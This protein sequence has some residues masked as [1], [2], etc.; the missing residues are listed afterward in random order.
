MKKLLLVCLL[1]AWGGTALAQS[2]VR[3]YGFLGPSSPLAPNAFSDFWNVGYTAGAAVGVRLIGA[4]EVVGGV[5]YHLFPIEED[6]FLG[7]AGVL[8]IDL[9]LDGGAI[10]V[11]SGTVRLKANLEASKRFAPYA[12]IGAG[13]HHRK[14]DD[15]T[16]SVRG[17]D[18]VT[19]EGDAE[20]TIGFE[21]GLGVGLI[22]TSRLQFYAEPSVT[23]L[24]TELS[25][26]DFN[27]NLNLA[28]SDN[29]RFL[30]VRFGVLLDL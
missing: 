13:V 6:E 22:L 11:L 8:G 29:T 30:P 21:A 24:A 12:F 14:L 9:A 3:L 1:A 16:I 20:T 10:S 7:D 26:R 18:S 28:K 5:S 19:F 27:L 15:F 2:N 25:K 23:V 17:G 4:F